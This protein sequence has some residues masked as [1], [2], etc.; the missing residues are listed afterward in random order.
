[1]AK[2]PLLIVDDE[3]L[4]RRNLERALDDHPDWEVAAS[5]QSGEE[6]RA[7]LET[8][9][10][11]QLVLFDIRMPGE[12]GLALARYLCGLA[13]QPLIAF[14]T[15]YDEYAI[16][17]FELFALDYLQKPFSDEQLTQLLGRAKA[18]SELRVRANGD[19]LRALV[20]DLSARETAASP[21]LLKYFTVRS[22]GSVERIALE[23][24]LSIRGAGNYVEL[25][26]RDRIVLHR[27]SLGCDCSPTSTRPVP[28]NLSDCNSQAR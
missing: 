20:G 2:R 19:L 27:A 6:A 7:W 23:D 5:C 15:A 21:P 11:V 25:R 17:A 8:G 13:N 14:V 3:P 26:L 9:H 4:A 28:S 16:D 22:I 1:M 18:M 12:G 10:K 24:V